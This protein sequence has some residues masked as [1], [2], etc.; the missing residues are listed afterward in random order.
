MTAFR[1]TNELK[2]D[3]DIP[4]ETEDE[5]KRF[6]EKYKVTCTPLKGA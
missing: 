1:R 2:A 3:I 4:L 6:W 5:F